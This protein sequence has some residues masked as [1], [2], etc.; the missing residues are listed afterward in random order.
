M[1]EADDQLPSVVDGLQRL[2]DYLT[3]ELG[4]IE[5]AIGIARLQSIR[6]TTQAVELTTQDGITLV[7]A[8][9]SSIAV[10][11]PDVRVATGQSLTVKKTDASG[12]AVTVTAAGTALIDGA[13][14]F[15]L[16]AQWQSVTVQSDSLNWYVR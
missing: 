10:T 12:N 11:L 5:A 2:A 13:S 7:D 6:T 14:T 1:P 8:T 4:A 9:A 15:P 3:R 16:T